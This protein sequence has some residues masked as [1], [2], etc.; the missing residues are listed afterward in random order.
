M[1]V[2]LGLCSRVYLRRSHLA[3][4]PLPVRESPQGGPD[5]QLDQPW[6]RW[7]R[8]F[9]SLS[10]WRACRGVPPWRCHGSAGGGGSVRADRRADV[11]SVV[12]CVHAFVPPRRAREA[13]STE[14][15]L[16]RAGTTAGDRHPALRSGSGAWLV[17]ASAFRRCDLYLHRRVL[18][19]DQPRHPPPPPVTGPP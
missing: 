13:A 2:L 17:R 15:N 16:C 6:N 9:D 7:Y 14:I 19:L 10:D 11:C 4:P 1:V 18:C 8:S 5:P 3:Q 12:T